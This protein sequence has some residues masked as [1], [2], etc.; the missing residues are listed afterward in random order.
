MSR[1]VLVN[2]RF[3]SRRDN[4]TNQMLCQKWRQLTDSL[5]SRECAQLFS[6]QFFYPQSYWPRFQPNHQIKLHLSK[7][8]Q[9]H[10]QVSTELFFTL[11]LYVCLTWIF[12][13]SLGLG[14]KPTRLGFRKHLWLPLNNCFGRHDHGWRW[15]DLPWKIGSFIARKFNENGSNC[16]QP[17]GRVGCNNA[18]RC[19]HQ[20]IRQQCE[21]HISGLAQMFVTVF[22]WFAANLIS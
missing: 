20:L 17:F 5:S 6:Q 4:R 11:Q 12:S 18:T 13:S 1:I 10:K 15:F 19:E 2:G 16:S 3:P 21:N 9:N 22:L 8:L 14:T 7:F